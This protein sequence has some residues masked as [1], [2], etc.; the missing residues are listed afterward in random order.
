M[1]SYGIEKL[2]SAIK[3]TYKRYTG[4]RTDGKVTLKDVAKFFNIPVD[5]KRTEDYII[6]KID[7][8]TPSI[9]IKDQKNNISYAATYT[10][11][12]E[13]LDFYGPTQF[14][15]VI[16]TSPIR[17]E[18]NLYYIGNDTPIIT[19]MTFTDGE[20]ELVFEREMPNSVGFVIQDGIEMSIKYLQNITHNDKV[21]KKQLFRKIYKI[22]E[23]KSNNENFNSS[24]ERF[25]T[26]GTQHRI[27]WGNSQDKY[28]YL[29]KTGVVYGIN[30]SEQKEIY[31]YLRGI[32][33]ENTDIPSIKSY[34]PLNLDSK[35]YPLLNDSNIKS[36]MILK[37]RTKDS[38]NHSLKIY[39]SDVI[40]VM[41]LSNKLEKFNED[42]H[43]KT[44]AQEEYGLP[45]LSDGTITSEEIQHIL[46]SLQK[47]L[48]NSIVFNVIKN[49]LNTFG[50]K[51]DVI[52]IRKEAVQEEPDPI[53]PKLFID[54]PFDEI[55]SLVSE[56]KD[57]YFKLIKEQFETAAGINKTKEKAPTKVLKS[58]NPKK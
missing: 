6:S 55:C 31:N 40:S 45:N 12:A 49:E 2:K 51:I 4:E 19:K 38:V 44:I 28:I 5:R 23:N 54:K 33:F 37:M 14:N 42:Y 57:D 1:E 3:I 8:D 10:G 41:Y 50:T 52:D 29:T 47:R 56:K 43:Y 24:F 11:R 21:V 39:K 32:C 30:E 17:T 26:F 22:Y 35:D 20:Y 36:A 34:F 9:E 15:S 16:S 27:K 46:S 25:Y 48:G 18:E 58:N 7:Y 13:L 53:S